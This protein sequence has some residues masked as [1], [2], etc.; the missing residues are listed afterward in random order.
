MTSA[1]ASVAELANGR[2]V[3]L[4]AIPRLAIDQFQR[5]I[6]NGVSGGQRVAAL[7][8]AVLGGRDAVDLHV[9]W[10]M[11]RPTGSWWPARPC[12]TTA[13]RR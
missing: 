3:D 5:V 13:S 7:F 2:S 11:T 12:R 1:G 4:D 10:P 6:V 8:G 9:F